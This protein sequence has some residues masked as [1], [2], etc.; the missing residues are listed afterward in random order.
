MLD[1]FM[2]LH[3]T[4]LEIDDL[5]HFS[6]DSTFTQNIPAEWLE[7]A[8]TLSSTATV[9]RRRL[10]SEQVLWLV[11]GMVLFQNENI[12]EVARRLNVCSQDLANE[13]LLAKSGVSCAR[14]KLGSE[15]LSGFFKKQGLTGGKNVTLA[16][17][18]MACKYWLWTGHYSAHQ[19][20]LNCAIT[21]VLATRLLIDKFR[22]Q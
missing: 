10:P 15:P 5:H 21:L 2:P 17:T 7:S 12:G 16:M 1:F 3:Q 4:L 6:D 18:G 22:T 13:N 19:I 9:R 11:L 8:L 20:R 14:Q